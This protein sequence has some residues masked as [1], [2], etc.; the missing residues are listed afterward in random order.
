MQPPNLRRNLCQPGGGIV[1]RAGAAAGAEPD[2]QRH[3]AD[4]TLQCA[5][6]GDGS[7]D[8]VPGQEVSHLRDAQ[9]IS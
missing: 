8:A 1:G 2:H 3:G 7:Q 9:T 5:L 4:T 6:L